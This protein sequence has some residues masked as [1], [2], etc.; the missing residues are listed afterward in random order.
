MLQSP[1]TP[2]RFDM[3]KKC[4]CTQVRFTAPANW[5]Q[6]FLQSFTTSCQFDMWK[7]ADV[8]RSDITLIR[9]PLH[10]PTVLSPSLIEPSATEPYYT[11]SVS[12][13]KECRHTQVRCTLPTLWTQCYRVVL[14]H[15]SLIC[16]RMQMYLG[17]MYHPLIKPSGTDPYF[18]APTIEPHGT[19]AYCT[20]C[21]VSHVEECRHV[22]RS[23]VLFRAPPRHTLNPTNWA[24][25][26]RALLHHVSFICERMQA[27]PGQMYTPHSL[28]PVLQSCTTPCQFDMWTECRCTQVRCTTPLIKPSGT[29]PYFIPSIEPH[30]TEAYCTRS[31]SHVEECRCTQVRCTPTEPY[32]TMSVWHVGQC[33]HTQSQMLHQVSLICD[34]MQMYPRSDIHP[35]LIEPSATEPYYTRSVWHV[36]ECRCTQVRCTPHQ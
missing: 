36:E 19:E 6:V 28:N 30:V 10:P 34:R 17:Q 2:C 27:Y 5:I 26:Y 11:R 16:D 7:N 4:R 1:T 14:H 33:R 23:D 31:V 15:V 22:P 3:W 13:V 18:S 24:Q 29:D 25:C 32:H 9:P 35:S 8:N 20:R 21:Q 12:H